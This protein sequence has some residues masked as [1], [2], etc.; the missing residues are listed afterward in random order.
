MSHTKHPVPAVRRAPSDSWKSLGA[1]NGTD[2][3]D[4]WFPEPGTGRADRDERTLGALRT[5]GGCF[6]RSQCLSYALANNERYGIWG[7]MT[8]LQR[9]A[10]VRKARRG[11]DAA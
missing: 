4:A 3:P 1:C 9:A 6:V 2:D 8:E 5:C 11:G 10:L 7:G